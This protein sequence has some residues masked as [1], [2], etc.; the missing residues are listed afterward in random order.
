MSKLKIYD[1]EL[2][3][4]LS[5]AQKILLASKSELDIKRLKEITNAMKM[6]QYEIV[7]TKAIENR[8]SKYALEILYNCILKYKNDIEYTEDESAQF[9][10]Y[11]EEKPYMELIK[12]KS[13][14]DLFSY[15]SGDNTL[16]HSDL[17]VIYLYLTGTKSKAKTKE[18]VLN[19]IK[20]Y[21][22]KIRNFDD[23]DSKYDKHQLM[24]S[25]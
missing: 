14:D 18:A 21:I 22:Y 17:C 25:V 10:I 23:M 3:D 5:V 20:A 24:G 19:E 7:P 9:K 1:K 13:Y 16:N 6:N 2:I 12:N 4:F 8:K 15:L 11:C